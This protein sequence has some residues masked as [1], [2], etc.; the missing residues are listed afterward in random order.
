MVPFMEKDVYVIVFQLIHNK[1]TGHAH[2]LDFTGVSIPDKKIEVIVM[3][4]DLYGYILPI[5]RL[6]LYG[7]M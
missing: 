3:F 5:N 1:V 2:F 6:N 7:P 4:H